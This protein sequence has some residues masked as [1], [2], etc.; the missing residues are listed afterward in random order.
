MPGAP[1][2]S[3]AQAGVCYNTRKVARAVTRMYDDMLRPSGL[4][5]TQLTLLMVIDALGEPSITE[6]AEQL[7]MDRTT[8]TRDLRPLGAAGWVAVTP[9]EDRRMRIVRLTS[10]GGI[11]LRDALSRWRAAQAALVDTGVGE[12]EWARLRG[13]LARLM[14]LAQRHPAT[15]ANRN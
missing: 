13:D 11:A 2:S 8:L 6:L 3:Q 14:T 15:S 10:D 5:A 7:V 9:G 1:E 12:G 4:R